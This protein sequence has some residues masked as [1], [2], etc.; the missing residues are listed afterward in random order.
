[1]HLVFKRLVP[2]AMLVLA[3]TAWAA[4]CSEDSPSYNTNNGATNNGTNNGANNGTNNGVNNG[5]TNNG[6][7]N[8]ANNSSGDSGAAYVFTLNGGSG[9][10]E[11]T[12]IIKASDPDNSDLFGRNVAIDGDAIV[13]G[14]YAEATGGCSC[15]A[16][17][18]RGT[19]GSLVLFLLVALR[20][21][22]RRLA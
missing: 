20:L 13:V 1:M 2:I 3:L 8:G 4:G 22:R 6:A 17:D 12:Q 7:N 5:A 11:E 10:F 14:A 15:R 21:S 16:V 18:G 19:S 9:L